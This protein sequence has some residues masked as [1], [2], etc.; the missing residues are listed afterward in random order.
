ML[1][2]APCTNVHASCLV[3]REPG[4]VKA[5]SFDTKDATIVCFSSNELLQSLPSACQLRSDSVLLGDLAVQS[6]LLVES[7]DLM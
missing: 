3:A 6:L 2:A 7:E 5:Q 1:H 4:C